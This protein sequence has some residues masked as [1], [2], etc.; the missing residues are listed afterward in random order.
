MSA[1]RKSILVAGIGRFISDPERRDTV[2]NAIAEDV[3]R[4]SDHG[5]DCKVVNLDIDDPTGALQQVKTELS[6][7]HWDAFSIGFEVRGK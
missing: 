2:M 4:A 1:T 7:Q 5:F 6:S 3:Q